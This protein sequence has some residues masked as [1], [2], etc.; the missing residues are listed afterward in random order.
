[1]SDLRPETRRFTLPDGEIS[2]LVWPKPGATRLIF[3]HGNGFNALSGKKLLERLA[4]H[5][6]I[7][8]PDLRGHGA[9][10]LPADPARHRDWYVY[11]R[12]MKAML[13]Q[14]DD[15]PF[16]LA[17]HSMGGVI[18][19]L[20]AEKLETKPLGLALIDPVILP[21][22][23][24]AFNH[25]PLW[26]LTW[27]RFPLVQGALRRG[28]FWPEV[29]AVKARYASRPPFSYWATGVLDDYLAGGLKPVEGGFA[30]ACDPHWEAA[31]YASHRHD[32]V[33][34][35]R[36]AGAPITVLK[37]EKAST[38]R[39]EA[40]LK[41]AGAVI[42]PLPGHSHLAPMENPAA[43]AEWIAGVVEGF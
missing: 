24:Y 16:V 43:C 29:Q 22:G 18:A 5:Y 27:R 11:T 37:A 34:A 4:D 9:T 10:T 7:I 42:T 33:R 26:H 20:T 32:P 12:D 21:G 19:L 39:D 35:A 25:T 13:D 36:R 38:V 14:L 28:N 31:N 30:L 1:M 40:G 3:L 41:R 8:A 17:G 6:E 23:F 2:A 15:R